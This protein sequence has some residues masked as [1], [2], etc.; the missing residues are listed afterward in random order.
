MVSRKRKR[1]AAYTTPEKKKKTQ[2]EAKIFV[3]N[4]PAVGEIPMMF[5]LPSN[6]N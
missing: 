1:T 4:L 2:K 6:E 3:M 5:Y